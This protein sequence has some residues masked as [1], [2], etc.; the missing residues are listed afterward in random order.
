MADF[1][2][3][4]DLETFMGATNLG[5]RGT[6]MLGYASAAIRRYTQQDLEVTTG[7]QE[8]WAGDGWRDVI[9]LTQR[10]V[11]AV[12]A[13][14]VD[15][16]AFTD[17]TWTRWGQVWKEDF[18]AWSEGPILVTYDS[19]FAANSDEMIQVKAICLEVAARAIGGN[20]DVFGM[21]EQEAR[22]FAP[23]VFLS[24]GEKHDLDGLGTVAVA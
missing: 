9:M 20:P 14:T 15:S 5:A 11:T 10:P 22:G 8:T 19:G 16:V 1:A 2:T 12:S 24:E 7:R 21:D 17:F 6:A 18:S 3:V 4:A 13:I 23:A